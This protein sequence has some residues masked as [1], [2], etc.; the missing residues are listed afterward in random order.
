[1]PNNGEPEDFVLSLPH[2]PKVA[3]GLGQLWQ[4]ILPVAATIKRVKRSGH[5]S[6]RIV[7]LLNRWNGEQLFR[8]DGVL[9]NYASEQAQEWLLRE[10]PEHVAFEDCEVK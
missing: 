3:K 2:S 10:V 4:L 1:M 6:E 7:V 8:A 9:Y 5:R